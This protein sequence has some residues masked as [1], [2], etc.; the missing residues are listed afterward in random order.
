MHSICPSVKRH[1]D[2]QLDASSAA[3]GA[4]APRGLYAVVDLAGWRKPA[5]WLVVIG[6]NSIA[7][8]MIAHLFE[9]SSAARCARTSAPGRSRRSGPRTSPSSW[10]AR[11]C[12]FLLL[13]DPVLDVPTEAVPAD[14]VPAAPPRR[15]RST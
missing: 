15:V 4:S 6:M 13:A 2:A 11:S 10:E 8:Y 3:A 14:L 5:F 1:L 9:T 12:F 7:A